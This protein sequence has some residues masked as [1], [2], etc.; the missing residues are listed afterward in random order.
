MSDRER[1]IERLGR[2][3]DVE[4]SDARVH[5][6]ERAMI[7]RRERRAKS[8]VAILGI[9]LA[10]AATLAVV[11]GRRGSGDAPSATMAE[12]A[13]GGHG[14]APPA[15][16][17]KLVAGPSDRGVDLPGGGRA[18][19]LD[20]SSAAVAVE[21]GVDVHGAARVVSPSKV[22][23]HVAAFLVDLPDGGEIVV[24][25]SADRARV[26]VT[27]ARGRASVTWGGATRD[28]AEGE[29]AEIDATKDARANAP[30]TARRASPSP[31]EHA[32]DARWRSLAGAGDYDAAYDAMRA[33]GARAVGD[34]A[35]DLLLAADVAR[36]SRH[37]AEAVAP[38][39]ALLRDHGDDARAPLAAF[40]LGR[41]LL[42]ELARPGDAA[43]AF[44]KARALA[45]SGSLAE[46]ALAR[47]VEAAARAGDAD[48]ARR[49]ADEYARLYPR[50]SRAAAV[51]RYGGV[52]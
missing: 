39:E 43:D 28:V 36:L 27:S 42:E 46:D 24:T 5:R 18:T 52:P 25:E 49:E 22:R 13:P 44:A 14:D 21:D 40:T 3:V 10:S 35:D 30:A 47:E 16:G 1:E 51:R 45:P 8:R 9:A 31:A 48:R 20:P 7:E 38:L 17:A 12:T 2:L 33:G 32:G 50:G 4:W 29:T 34:A 15:N 23:V 37:P 6:V 11:A 41:V 19:P 26:L